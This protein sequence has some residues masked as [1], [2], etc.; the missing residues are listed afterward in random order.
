MAFVQ[1]GADAAAQVFSEGNMTRAG[2]EAQ[3]R[4]FRQ[5]RII[6]GCHGAGLTNMVF[7]PAGTSV[8]EFPLDP[9]VDRSFGCMAASLGFEYWLV[10]QLKSNYQQNY[11]MTSALADEVVKVVQHVIY[12]SG[13]EAMLPTPSL[14]RNT[15][16]SATN[17]I[18]ISQH[19]SSIP[20]PESVLVLARLSLPLPQPTN[21]PIARPQRLLYSV[22]RVDIAKHLSK[23][24][25]TKIKKMFDSF[26]L[27][28]VL[29][30]FRAW[31]EV[32]GLVEQ[33]GAQRQFVKAYAACLLFSDHHPRHMEV[34]R[35]DAST[36]PY[37]HAVNDVRWHHA[38]PARRPGR[39]HR[40]VQGCRRLCSS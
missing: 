4:V 9:H 21:Q 28:V 18:S 3:I 24:E 32:A 33:L 36:N 25:I 27:A 35:R 40:G 20:Y 26:A 1:T 30:S 5:A 38:G 39:C 31:A 23:T 14:K 7:A 13:L 8:I 15:T 29:N 34:A 2:L 37:L 16:L 11:T 19:N 22:A 6:V 12:R 10:P 17:T